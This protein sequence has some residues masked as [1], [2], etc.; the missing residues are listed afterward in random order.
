MKAPILK[1]RD[2]VKTMAAAGAGLLL[3]SS[4]PGLHAEEATPD[5][6]VRRVLV[7]FKCHFDAGFV[8]T[9]YNVVHHR[10]FQKFFPQAIDIARSA[11]AGGQRRYVWTTGSWLLY[12]YLEQ[13]SQAERKATEEAIHRGDL[14]WHALPFSWQSEMLPPSMI[15]GSLALSRSLDK[16]FGA[17]T[18]GAKMTDV[19]GHTRALWLRWP[20]A[21]L[22]CSKSAP[23]A[24]PRPP[25]FRHCF[26]GRTPPEQACP[27]CITTSTAAWPAY[28]VPIWC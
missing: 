8:D 4:L 9:Q 7:M 23:T 25:R 11:N 19:P 24:A 16:R 17:T 20:R 26:C 2:F 13:A 14:A 22:R 12:E 3:D 5:P 1:R 10:Y 21:A 27:S 28:R 18:T 6:A 15:E